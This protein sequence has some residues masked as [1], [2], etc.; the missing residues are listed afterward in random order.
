M[1][2]ETSRAGGHRRASRYFGILRLVGSTEQLHGPTEHFR[3]KIRF[4]PTC[5][6]FLTFKNQLHN[7]NRYYNIKKQH[8]IRGFV[9]FQT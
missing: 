6:F 8:Y 3:K 9:D 1:I 7:Y 5:V 4:C 2:P